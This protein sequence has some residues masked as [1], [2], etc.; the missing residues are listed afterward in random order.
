[1]A[2]KPKPENRPKQAGRQPQKRNATSFK[3]GQSGNPGGRPK[4][5]GEFRE[6]MRERLTEKAVA[7][8][9]RHLA[10]GVVGADAVRSAVEALAFAWGRPAQ[11][12]EMSGPEGAAIPVKAELVPN[13][14]PDQLASVLGLL[15]RVGALARTS[16]SSGTGAAADA[17]A[18]EVHPAQPED[19][20]T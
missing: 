17:E 13:A 12:V 18:D 4:G 10:R 19:G 2:R 11:A 1:M 6:M 16:G 9:E 14:D 5:L 7:A 20:G 15:G 8:L 3:P